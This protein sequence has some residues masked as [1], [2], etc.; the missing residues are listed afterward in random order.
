[1]VYTN[2]A[3]SSMRVMVQSCF[4]IL[5]LPLQLDFVVHCRIIIL[6]M[7]VQSHSLLFLQMLYYKVLYA[8]MPVP[9][10]LIVPLNFCVWLV[11][12]RSSISLALSSNASII[13]SATLGAAAAL[14]VV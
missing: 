7:H 5:V 3:W 4:G 2:D 11:A 6:Q 8:F 12:G 9:G 1:M 14:N 10:A 13:F